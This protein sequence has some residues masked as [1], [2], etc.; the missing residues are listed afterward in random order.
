[1]G[2]S[3]YAVQ[4]EFRWL[5]K[6]SDGVVLLRDTYDRDLELKM[7]GYVIFRLVASDFRFA[8]HQKKVACDILSGQKQGEITFADFQA[9]GPLLH[10]CDYLSYPIVFSGL[11]LENAKVVR[12]REFERY[13]IGLEEIY[14]DN[15][16]K[17]QKLKERNADLPSSSFLI[18]YGSGVAD[19]TTSTLGRYGSLSLLNSYL[20]FEGG[21]GVPSRLISLT[22]VTSIVAKRI[23]IVDNGIVLNMKSG[24]K[25]SFSFASQRDRWLEAMVELHAAWQVSRS[26][27][28]SFVDAQ[29]YAPIPETDESENFLTIPILVHFA[30]HNIIRA[31]VL[32]RLRVRVREGMVRSLFYSTQL[33]KQLDNLSLSSHLFSDWVVGIETSV[34]V[35]TI[36]DMIECDFTLHSSIQYRRLVVDWSLMDDQ[37]GESGEVFDYSSLIRSMEVLAELVQP[38]LVAFYYLRDIVTWNNGALTLAILLATIYCMYRGLLEYALSLAFLSQLL[39]LAYCRFYLWQE[40]RVV[41][42]K[43]AEEE[44]RTRGSNLRTLFRALEQVNYLLRLNRDLYSWNNIPLTRWYSFYLFVCGI[45]VAL[46]PFRWL[47]ILSWL[48]L[49]AFFAVKVN[50]PNI[51]PFFVRSVAAKIQKENEFTDVSH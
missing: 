35:Q 49:L 27:A 13:L 20:F 14:V 24:N 23:G 12:R 3:N 8:F 33:L 48:V 36:H 44:F 26:I 5:D 29:K 9:V 46:V 21:P 11:L 2:E 47:C 28:A 39:L 38:Y 34:T 30:S 25:V 37:T 1:M 40:E 31:K 4:E 45:A 15:R 22:N 50:F 7:N 17:L 32:R 19:H 10:I 16:R 6:D 43:R 18:R 42:T 41:T 51:I